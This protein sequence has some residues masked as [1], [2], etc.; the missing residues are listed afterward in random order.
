M[1]HRQTPQVGFGDDE[2]NDGESYMVFDIT[3]G[4]TYYINWTNYYSEDGFNWTLEESL[5]INIVGLT[6]CNI[7]HHI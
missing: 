7:K 6:F 1:K 2:W 3:E 4:E 5:P